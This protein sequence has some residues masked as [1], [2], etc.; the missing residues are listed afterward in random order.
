MLAIVA[1][2]ITIRKLMLDNTVKLKP[3]RHVPTSQALAITIPMATCFVPTVVN[4]KSKLIWAVNVQ[5]VFS[6]YACHC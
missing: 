3:P 2:L 1:L 4:A 5:L 6:K